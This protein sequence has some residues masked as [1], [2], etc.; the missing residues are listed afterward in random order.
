MIYADKNLWPRLYRLHREAFEL[1]DNLNSLGLDAGFKFFTMRKALRINCASRGDFSVHFMRERC[2]G[3]A[4][5][6]CDLYGRFLDRQS[7]AGSPYE[8][9]RE[10]ERDADD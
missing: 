7:I 2:H 10:G 5:R 8:E 4:D 3:I 6:G 9:E 1:T